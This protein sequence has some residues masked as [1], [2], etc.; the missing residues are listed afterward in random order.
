MLFKIG[1]LKFQWNVKWDCILKQDSLSS[2][3]NC[4]LASWGSSS[5]RGRRGSPSLVLPWSFQGPSFHC[6]SR[7]LLGGVPWP[8]FPG[9]SNSPSQHHSQVLPAVLPSWSFWGDL[10]LHSQVLPTVLPSIIPRSFQQSF[11]A[12]PSGGTWVFIP[13]SFQQSFLASFPGPSSS[14]SQLVLP[15]GSHVT[16][17]IMPEPSFQGP[18]SSPSHLVLLGGSHMIYPIMHLMLPVCSPDTN[19]LVWLDAAASILLGPP[20]SSTDWQ[21]CLKTLV[22]HALRMRAVIRFIWQPDSLPDA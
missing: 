21:T 17:P 14:P 7:V 19:W 8:S 5:G 18:S 1:N 15:G 13:R 11:P 22:S 16:Y 2:M 10:S 12:G 6:P 4:P 3:A 20:W 9:P